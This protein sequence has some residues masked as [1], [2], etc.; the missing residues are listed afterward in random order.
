MTDLE[1]MIQKIISEEGSISFERFMEYAL[2]APQWGYYTRRY[3]KIGQAGD[4]T[5]APEISPLFGYALAV[6]CYPMLKSF[7]EGV[8]IEL[9]A[10]T[11]QLCVDLLTELERLDALPQ[12]YYIKE[13]S[14][15]LIAHQRALIEGK[16][17]HLLSRVV[18]WDEWPNETFEGVLIANE[19]LD[20]LPVK[21]FMKTAEGLWESYI[22]VE[23]N[24]FQEVFLPPKH[25]LFDGLK[26]FAE[27]WPI[28]YQ[29]ELNTAAAS[30]LSDCSKVLKKGAMIWIDYGFPEHEYYHP[31]RMGGTIMCHYQHKTHPN[32]L[33]NVGE[34]DVTAH[35][36][37]TQLADSAYSLGWDIAGY[38]NQAAYLV[39]LGIVERAESFYETNIL[40][41]REVLSLLLNPSEMGELFKVMVLTKA[42]S[43]PL[44]GTAF[45]DKRNQ[46]SME[47]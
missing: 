15:A 36:N 9:G 42:W 30:L 6:E 18:W 33:I 8:L 14:P 39:S 5:T 26:S 1:A 34:Q 24:A 21:R 45:L 23:N 35:V 28:G 41:K 47:I 4:F 2:Y 16:I 43:A 38:T 31:D 37:F 11:G 12:N 29:S 25:H 10:G 27:H 13:V 20:A 17:P 3:P 44:K 22:T 32:P 46:L 7:H 40:K 19:V